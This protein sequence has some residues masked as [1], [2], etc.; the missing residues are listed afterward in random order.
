MAYLN[1]AFCVMAGA[2]FGWL[3]HDFI[4]HVLLQQ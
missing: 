4:W 2:L 3:S 1:Y